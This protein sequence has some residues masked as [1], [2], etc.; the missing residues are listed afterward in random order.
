MLKKAKSQL[1]S[2]LNSYGIDEET[3]LI[4]ANIRKIRKNTLGYYA[5]MSQFRGRARIVVDANAIRSLLAEADGGIE[6]QDWMVEAEVLKT[7]AHE[8]G[9]I[10]AE[11][12]RVSKKCDSPFNVPCWEAEFYDEEDFARMLI[13]DE[14]S[15]SIWW[16]SFMPQYAKEFNRLFIQE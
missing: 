4:V 15:H 8:Y 14:A 2:A 13:E 12:M 5:N 3:N 1:L 7:I 9:H 10:M 6:P 11:A 16:I